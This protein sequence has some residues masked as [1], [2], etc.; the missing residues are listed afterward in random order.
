VLAAL[1]TGGFAGHQ[2]DDFDVALFGRSVAHYDVD[3]K[4]TGRRSFNPSGI[5]G[6]GHGEP[7]FAGALAF[8]DLGWT[9]GPDPI[10]YEHPRFT[11]VLP[12]AVVRLRRRQLGAAGILD[13]PATGEPVLAEL[14]W[15]TV[16]DDDPD[17]F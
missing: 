1:F 12:S 2:V 17:E 10:L 11:G 8:A 4:D 6:R 3:M 9:G 5:F 16:T 15:P 7:T 13:I 14:G